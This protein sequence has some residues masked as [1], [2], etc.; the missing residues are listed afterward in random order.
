VLAA[1]GLWILVLLAR[2]FNW[3]KTLLVASM[4]GAIVLILIIEPLRDF[5]ALQLPPARVLGVAAM[6]AGGA[7]LLLEIGWRASRV[8]ASRRSVA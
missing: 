5:Y 3:W 1:V 8:V 6:I 2:P 4:A 7:I